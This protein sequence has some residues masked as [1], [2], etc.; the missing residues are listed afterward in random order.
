[1]ELRTVTSKV[2]VHWN[3]LVP[4]AKVRPATAAPNTVLVPVLRYKMDTV[5]HLNYSS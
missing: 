3:H 1:M 5:L 2:T 4:C